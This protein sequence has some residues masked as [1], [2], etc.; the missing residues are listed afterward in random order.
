MV[1]ATMPFYSALLLV[2]F[3]AYLSSVAASPVDLASPLTTLEDRQIANCS[4]LYATPSASCWD[5]LK[6]PD[7]LT[8]WKAKTPICTSTDDG[9]NCCKPNEAWSTCFL[10]LATGTTGSDC[11]TIAVGSCSNSHVATSLSPD[12]VV[13]ANY[14]VS[15]VVNIQNI[16]VGYFQGNG[17]EMAPNTRT[18]S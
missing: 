8:G 13:Q 7:Y 2:A 11:T 4:D 16:F 1:V 12:I 9:S 18:C 5:Q 15:T 3:P 6:I 10:R 14:V 17:P